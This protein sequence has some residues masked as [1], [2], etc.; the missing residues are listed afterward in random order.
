MF[1]R[2]GISVGVPACFGSEA[3]LYLN[4]PSRFRFSVSV[5]VPQMCFLPENK[6]GTS[7]SVS[8]YRQYREEEELCKIISKAHSGFEVVCHAWPLTSP[9]YSQKTDWELWTSKV[10]TSMWRQRSRLYILQTTMYRSRVILPG[11][12]NKWNTAVW[13]RMINA[14][15]NILVKAKMKIIV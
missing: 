5:T 6:S 3:H 7:L 15:P 14:P 10:I 12:I 1:W 9:A 2:N 4:V 11:T 13:T 8:F